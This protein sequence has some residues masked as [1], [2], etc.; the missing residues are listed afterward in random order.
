MFHRAPGRN[1][2]LSRCLYL[3]RRQRGVRMSVGTW[4]ERG[5]RVRGLRLDVGFIAFVG[6]AAVTLLV[7]L[8]LVERKFAIF[9]GGFG[10]PRTIGDPPEIIA[11]C[12]D[13][14]S[15]RLNSSH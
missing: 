11:F 10:Q 9:G 7:E 8:V 3:R 2:L 6:V 15:T 12:A 13:R 5:R 1:G 14:K 4:V